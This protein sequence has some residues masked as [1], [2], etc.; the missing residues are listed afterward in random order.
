MLFC[1]G[2]VVLVVSS[3]FTLNDDPFATLLKK[4]AE[5]TKNYPTEKV[6][7]HLDKPY[8]A[9]GEDIWFKAY[10]TDSRTSAPTAA[11]R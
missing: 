1:F 2:L 10:V 9:I 5:F 4:L 3:A 6:H 7:L 11:S 8:Y